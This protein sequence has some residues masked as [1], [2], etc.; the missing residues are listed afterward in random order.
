MVKPFKLKILPGCVFRQLNP[1]I[2]GVEV[3]IGTAR[4]NTPLMNSEGKK[5]TDLKEIQDNKE[6][7]PEAEQG[8]E[9][10]I[11]LPN[12]TCGRQIH[13]NDVLYSD[14]PQ[15]DFKKLK[16]LMKKY[17]NDSEVQLLK[18]IAEIKRKENPTWGM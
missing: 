2:V 16:K 18:E 8:K 4:A 12:I 3:L 1:A 15:E 17:L 11:S 6:T 7:V 14:I 5:L 10:A 13:E 9:V